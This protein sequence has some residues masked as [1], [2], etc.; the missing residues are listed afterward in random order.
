MTH[1]WK[2]AAEPPADG[3]EV[4]VMVNNGMMR[5]A[6]AHSEWAHGFYSRERYVTRGGKRKF[7]ESALPG[8][9]LWLPA[10]PRP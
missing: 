9:T 8:V 7:R 3:T 5:I 10:P 1:R 4:I 2:K 6:I